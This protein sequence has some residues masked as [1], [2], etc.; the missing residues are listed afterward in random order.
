VALRRKILTILGN[1]VMSGFMSAGVPTVSSLIP[2]PCQLLE[3]IE[4]SSRS[5]LLLP[6]EPDR[7]LVI[8]EFLVTAS[9]PVRLFARSL[10]IIAEGRFLRNCS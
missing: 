9:V 3:F 8:H 2:H 10:G 4:Y 5:L 6:Y 7:V 1:P